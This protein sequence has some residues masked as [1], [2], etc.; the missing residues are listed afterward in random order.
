MKKIRNILSVLFI[1]L[2]TL[3]AVGAY[4]A[5]L[6]DANTNTVEEIIPAPQ[7]KVLTNG[8]EIEIA[9]NQSHQV[10][11]YALTG[12]IVKTV[13]ATSGVTNIELPAG[14]Y[15]VKVDKLAKRV[16]IK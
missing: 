11:V 5:D 2:T 4:A 15:I 13:E 7:I 14:Y 8:V 1:T 12:Q 10:C 16:I 9:D 6:S 3:C